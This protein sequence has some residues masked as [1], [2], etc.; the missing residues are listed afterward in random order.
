LLVSLGKQ[1]GGRGRITPDGGVGCVEILLYLV[2]HDTVSRWITLP[3]TV[4][5]V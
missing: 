3:A 5:A 1:L 4:L 2:S